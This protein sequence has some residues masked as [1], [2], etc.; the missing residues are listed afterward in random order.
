RALRSCPTRRASDLRRTPQRRAPTG[1]TG[2]GS[3]GVTRGPISTHARVSLVK[4]AHCCRRAPP[5]AGR[6]A[7]GRA[8]SRPRPPDLPDSMRVIIIIQIGSARPAPASACAAH[9]FG[10][11]P[12]DRDNF[13]MNAYRLSAAGGALAL[14]AIVLTGVLSLALAPPANRE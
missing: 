1:P 11:P 4:G 7:P 12:I 8:A 6:R 5:R 10:P 9:G 2:S 3:P 14:H 13:R